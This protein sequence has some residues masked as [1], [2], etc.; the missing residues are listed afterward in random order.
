MSYI[1]PFITKKKKTPPNNPNF[2]KHGMLLRKH[3]CVCGGTGQGKSGFVMNYIA[4]MSN[5]FKHI[6]IFSADPNDESYEKLK[7]SA[8][9][10]GADTD[11]IHLHTL[12][13]LIPCNELEDGEKLLIIDDWI[14]ESKKKK[15]ELTKY[16]ILSRKYQCTALYLAQ[17]WYAT[18][19]A[20]RLQ[21]RYAVFCG[22]P[23]NANLNQIVR[24]LSIPVDKETV[25]EA[26]KDATKK[27]YDQ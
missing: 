18:P 25:I 12:N 20:M 3:A 13:E 17:S 23:N 27:P 8:H 2:D 5:V 9:C 11:Q 4:N 7:D 1:D 15:D 14:A 22:A 21:M 19:P 24:N 10:S 6:Y 26:I 16:A